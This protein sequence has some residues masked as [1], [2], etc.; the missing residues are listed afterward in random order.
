M[1]GVPGPGAP[2][3]GDAGPGTPGI[4][5]GPDGRPAGPTRVALA[6]SVPSLSSPRGPSSGIAG[7]LHAHAHPIP[8]AA[9]RPDRPGPLLLTPAPRLL[10]SAPPPLYAEV[11]LP[12][13]G[14]TQ[15]CLCR[16]PRCTQRCLCRDPGVRRGASAATPLY[17]EV[18]LPRPG[19]TQRCLCRERG[20]R[21]GASAYSWA[22]RGCRR[23]APQPGSAPR[24]A[25]LWRRWCHRG[26]LRGARGRGGIVS[27]RWRR[28]GGWRRRRGRPPRRRGC[29]LSGRRCWLRRRAA[30]TGWRARRGRVLPRRGPDP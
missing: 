8:R 18:P 25:A 7:S 19:C 22:P 23:G 20:V 9:R 2:E 11:P 5:R 6:A 17:A 14:C 28:R 24:R 13:P 30:S 16:D 26:L 3:L 15:R 21:K 12:R 29:G 4:S 10:P 1:P 27:G